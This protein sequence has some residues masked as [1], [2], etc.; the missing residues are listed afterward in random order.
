MRHATPH[1][2]SCAGCPRLV[3]GQ[4]RAIDRVQCQRLRPID[5][6]YYAA[7]IIERLANLPDEQ[8]FAALIGSAMIDAVQKTN[9]FCGPT[10]AD[11][12]EARAWLAGRLPELAAEYAGVDRGTARGV[13]S[14][15]LG[16]LEQGEGKQ[17]G[18]TA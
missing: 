13:I 8:F 16:A 14:R 12:A 9:R 4:C 5:R 3:D 7:G 17:K 18:M 15:F 1:L 2:T 11:R 6:A 10:P